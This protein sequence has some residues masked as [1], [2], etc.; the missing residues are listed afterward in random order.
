MAHADLER[1]MQNY[2]THI[3]NF[4]FNHFL[5]ECGNQGVMVQPHHMS[6]MNGKTCVTCIVDNMDKFLLFVDG[7]T[8]FSIHIVSD[9]VVKIIYT[10]T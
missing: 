6:E 7:S 8:T 3:M 4:N 10:A 2:A 1:T 9:K 5:K